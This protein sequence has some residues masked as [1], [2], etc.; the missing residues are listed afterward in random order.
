MARLRSLSRTAQAAAWTPPRSR[1]AAARPL[2]TGPAAL[3]TEQPTRPCRW[4]HPRP[5]GYP[6]PAAAQVTPPQLDCRDTTYS[7]AIFVT[8]PIFYQV[9]PSKLRSCP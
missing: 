4:P 6:G 1:G 5:P 9:R 8:G 3:G 2:R 7:F